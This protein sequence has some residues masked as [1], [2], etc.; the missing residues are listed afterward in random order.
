MEN[1]K[2]AR[3]I[4]GEIAQA[5]GEEVIVSV[6]DSIAELSGRSGSLQNSVDAGHIAAGPEQVQEVV[7]DIDYPGKIPLILPPKLS[8]ELTKKEFDVVIVGGGV[9]GLAIARELSRFDL[10]IAL[11][12]RHHD[13]GMDQ[14]AHCNAMIHPALLTERGTLKWEMN[15]KGNAMWDEVAS[16]LDVDFKRIGTLVVAENPDEELFLPGVVDLA[17]SQN[18]P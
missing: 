6:R 7:N 14:T 5:T 3:T 9:I 2:L 18:D 1:E 12:E 16:Q 8:D 15:Y 17:R 10:R 4:K 11:I 13:L